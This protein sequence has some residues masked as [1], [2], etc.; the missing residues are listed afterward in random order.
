VNAWIRVGRYH[1]LQRFDYLALPWLW[2]AFGF[3]V[4]LV[5]FALIP[6]SHH[7]VLTGHG[8]TEM[9]NI[10]GRNAGA[11]GGIVLVFFVLGLLSA[12]RALPFA[13]TLGLSRRTYYVGTGLLAAALAITYGL[14]LAGLQAVERI[15]GGWGESAQIFQV[16]HILDGAWYVTWLTSSVV[17]VW[18]FVYGLWFGFVYRRWNLIGTLVLA[19]AQVTVLVVAAVVITWLRAWPATGRFL[20]ALS[21]VGLTGLLAVLAAVS[22]A[23]GYAAIRRIAV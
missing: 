7:M 2:L 15:T 17:L 19:A 10:S 1:L 11:L 8:L 23:G 13:L 3:A 20:A 9:P 21:A 4:D 6:V 5:I 22:L 12:A 14:V 16:P 18:L